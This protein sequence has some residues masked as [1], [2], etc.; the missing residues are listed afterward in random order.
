MTIKPAM[1]V[2]SLASSQA[3]LIQDRLCAGGSRSLAALS[4]SE[5]RGG[6]R[7]GSRN[8][9]QREGYS[10][11]LVNDGLR[12]QLKVAVLNGVLLWPRIELR[13][14]SHAPSRN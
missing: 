2:F 9:T 5:D 13:A 1:S 11:F 6:N 7:I 4:P 8:L 10:C 14:G 3:L 12:F